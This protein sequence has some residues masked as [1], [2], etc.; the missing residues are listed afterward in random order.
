VL[1]DGVVPAAAALVAA[2]VAP[3]AVDW[4]LP[5]HLAPEPAHRIALDRLG[6][7]PVL[8][9]GVRL[10]QGAGALAALPLLRAAVLACAETATAAEAGLTLR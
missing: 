4:W 3:A 5:A 10:G 2:A 9:L 6:L 1:L 8:E 7:V